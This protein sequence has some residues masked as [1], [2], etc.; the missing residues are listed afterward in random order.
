MKSY[1]PGIISFPCDLSGLA[2]SKIKIEPSSTCIVLVNKGQR[3]DRDQCL[4]TGLLCA[5]AAAIACFFRSAFQRVRRLLCSC[6]A[7]KPCND[8]RHGSSQ[9]MNR[10]V[11]PSPGVCLH[12]R[13]SGSVL[14]ESA[15]ADHNAM[16]RV[17]R[18]KEITTMILAVF[19]VR[20][21]HAC[22]QKA[23]AVWCSLVS[24]AGGFRRTARGAGVCSFSWYSCMP[25]PF[26]R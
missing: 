8:L 13:A 9:E 10:Q 24:A 21:G 19:F 2:L 12:A 4:P 1:C 3:R 11:F 17:R 20:Q 23:C 5:F 16:E 15:I 14:P 25:W 22:S 6:S 18:L 7:P 26:A